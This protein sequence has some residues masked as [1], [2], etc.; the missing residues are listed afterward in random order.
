MQLS[1]LTRA[2][3]ITQLERA[4]KRYLVYNDTES[5]FILHMQLGSVHI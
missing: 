4:L 1:F 2:L 3:G 5:L